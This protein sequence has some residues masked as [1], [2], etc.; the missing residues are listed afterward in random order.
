MPRNVERAVLLTASRNK[1]HTV[2]NASTPSY[3]QAYYRPTIDLLQASC[4][5]TDCW[6][7][8][9]LR[10]LQVHGRSTITLPQLNC[11]VLQ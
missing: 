3:R 2:R 7:T 6:P 8:A 4:R 1:R 5:A 11:T 9:G 10:L